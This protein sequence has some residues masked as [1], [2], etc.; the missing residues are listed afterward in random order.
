MGLRRSDASSQ[1]PTEVTT[2]DFRVCS[3]V[4]DR[5]R[6]PA[7]VSRS[8]SCHSTVARQP[9]SH[10]LR[11]SAGQARKF[12][13]DSPK[14]FETL[15]VLRKARF[16]ESEPTVREPETM[17]DA[18][19][20]ESESA[21]RAACCLKAEALEPH[22][23]SQN[24]RPSIPIF[25]L[26]FS[27]VLILMHVEGDIGQCPIAIEGDKSEWIWKWLAALSGK[28][29]RCERGLKLFKLS[30]EKLMQTLHPNV[31]DEGHTMAD[32]TRQ[33]MVILDERT[34]GSSSATSMETGLR[35]LSH[36]LRLMSQIHPGGQILST[37][38]EC[39][40]LK[41]NEASTE[42]ADEELVQKCAK[43][44][45]K[46]VQSRCSRCDDF[47]FHEGRLFSGKE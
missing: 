35:S 17:T 40:E 10:Q 39:T 38:E 31:F 47:S 22:C 41:T 44:A 29:T 2:L 7:K 16:A 1:L 6:A 32:V 19:A 20:I 25:D 28:D 23:H 36:S 21:R 11:G 12:V 3:N 42:F 5:E 24:F 33:L 46:V 9:A 18:S 8:S 30:L 37:T 34:A 13:S 45:T 14:G 26:C 15:R 27:M 43:N 4:G